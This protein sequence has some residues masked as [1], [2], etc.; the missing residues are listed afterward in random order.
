MQFIDV[1]GLPF[2]RCHSRSIASP[3]TPDDGLVAAGRMTLKVD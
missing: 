2:E 3:G 1:N